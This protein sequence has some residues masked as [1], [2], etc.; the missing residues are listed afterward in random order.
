[1]DINDLE[2]LFSSPKD[3][4]HEYFSNLRSEIDGLYEKQKNVK[5]TDE[6][7]Q[8][9]SENYE[10]LI[11]KLKSLEDECLKKII[12]N[13]YEPKVTTESGEI[14]NEIKSKIWWTKQ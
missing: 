13:K 6:I 2:L 8:K 11:S 12:T 4:I 9:L 14:L 7:K 5:T 10:K 1:M 3:Y